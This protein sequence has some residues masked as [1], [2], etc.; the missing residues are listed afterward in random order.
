MRLLADMDGVIVIA[1]YM[2]PGEMKVV[3]DG[4]Y[5]IETLFNPACDLMKLIVFRSDQIVN[6]SVSYTH[7]T[8]P[9]IYSV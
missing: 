5:A 7:L 3:K 6:V 2:N 9:T 8:L 1:F 4:R